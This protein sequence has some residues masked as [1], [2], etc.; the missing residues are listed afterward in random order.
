MITV[1]PLAG[2]ELPIQLAAVLNS[3]PFFEYTIL[4]KTLVCKAKI[5]DN[6]KT[7]FLMANRTYEQQTENGF[8]LI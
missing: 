3:P 5:I 1:S 4:A 7:T 8:V 2:V 6:T